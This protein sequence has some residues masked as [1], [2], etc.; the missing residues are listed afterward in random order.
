M[1]KT[2]G[3]VSTNGTGH[4]IS[5]CLFVIL[6][7]PGKRTKIFDFTTNVCLA[8]KRTKRSSILILRLVRFSAGQTLWYLKSNCFHSFFGRIEDTK[9]ISKL[10]DLLVCNS[11]KPCFF[12]SSEILVTKAFLKFGKKY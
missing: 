1:I 8:K 7:S 6:D 11:K 5:K 4:L 2:Y 10:T 12:Y 3:I 9:N